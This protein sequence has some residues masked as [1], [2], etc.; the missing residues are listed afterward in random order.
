MP[1]LTP[2]WS[3]LLIASNADAHPIMHWERRRKSRCDLRSRSGQSESGNTEQ[4]FITLGVLGGN[5]RLDE[6]IGALGVQREGVTQRSQLRTFLNKRLL[7][8]ISSCMEVLLRRK[9]ANKVKKS[10]NRHASVLVF[11]HLNRLQPRI[12]NYALFGCQ[13]LGFPASLP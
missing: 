9:Q 5:K 3:D 13:S 11:T 8:P 4:C 1:G 7:Q 12:H 6:G 10:P 2:V